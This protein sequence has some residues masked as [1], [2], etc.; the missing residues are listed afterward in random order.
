MVSETLYIS[1]RLFHS[2]TIV[3]RHVIDRHQRARLSAKLAARLGKL[4]D[5]FVN[6]NACRIDE[7]GAPT[8]RVRPHHFNVLQQQRGLPKC[9]GCANHHTSARGSVSGNV[10]Q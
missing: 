5:E 7:A 4:H 8:L 1:H 3:C 9:P 2:A 6:V 10:Q